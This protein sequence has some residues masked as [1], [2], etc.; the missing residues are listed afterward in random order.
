MAS[1]YHEARAEKAKIKAIQQ[2]NKRRA[3]RRAELEV[4]TNPL[5]ALRIDG[6]PC[7][8]IRNQDAYAAAE[9]REGMLAWNGNADNMIDRFDGR[10]LLDFYKDP[11][12]RKKPEK[13]D[14]ELELEELVTFEGFRD[15][16]KLLRLS[17]SE[18]TGIALAEDENLEM[19][20]SA[21]ST[22]IGQFN[23]QT[24]PPGPRSS[25]G[26]PAGSGQYGAVGFSYNGATAADSSG[27]DSE[28][29]D[30]DL[31]EPAP[32]DINVD[33]LAANLGIDAFSVLL[34]R[35]EREEA[36]MAEG[37]YKRRKR[38]WSRKTAAQRAK[39]M[40]GQG[41]GPLMNKKPDILIAPP[42]RALA[43]LPRRDSPTYDSYR[44]DSRSRSR[45]ES[46]SPEAPRQR[47]EYITEFKATKGRS[48]AHGSAGSAPHDLS[49][50]KRGEAY[51][52]ALP[53]TA[54]P[55]VLGD[56]PVSLPPQAVQMQGVRA[57]DS[58]Y[59]SREEERRHERARERERDLRRQKEAAPKQVPVR[60]EKETPMERLK[61][62]RAAQLNKTYQKEVVS[63]QQRKLQE[64]RDRAARESLQRAAYRRSP[65]P[66]SPRYRRQ[67]RSR[68]PNRR[69]S[70]SNDSY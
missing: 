25:T 47:S 19:R 67:N 54:D 27:S 51:R 52:D 69:G 37:I 35:A 13:T 8:L 60:K 3:E 68:S 45:S 9:A 42:S 10:A 20:A 30:E 49:A 32:E 62:L 2:D 59:V 55:A 40:A 56:G 39:R 12:P 34:R 65:S 4:A 48:H 15:L 11:D 5:D 14:E 61:R 28:N 50:P 17:I 26:I 64:E 29:S 53:Q 1:Y 70:S 24:A 57:Y 44:R 22:A 31:D 7:K 23:Q 6:R 38:R 16:V 63:T 66:P 21:K 41:L 33:S 46:R 36:E 43:R 18:E 58:F